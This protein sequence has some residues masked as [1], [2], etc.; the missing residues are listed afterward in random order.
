MYIIECKIDSTAKVA[1][2]QIHDKEYSLPWTLDKQEKVLI[3]VN[4]STEKRRP[5]DW[6][7]ERG[8]GKIVKSVHDSDQV[9]GQ[10]RGQA[11]GQVRGQVQRLVLA[12]ECATLSRQEI[13]DALHLR[14]RD[15]F[16]TNYLK[17]AMADEYIA[18]SIP[19]TPND[20]N[21]AYY[22]TEKGLAKLR[23]LKGEG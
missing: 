3:G 1:L 9:R 16:I 4:F 7:V 13:M 20:P 8:D 17:P 5:D 10:V 18:L 14:S 19:E 23:E 11:R 22:L 6:V 15:K 2:Q 21:Q 12:I